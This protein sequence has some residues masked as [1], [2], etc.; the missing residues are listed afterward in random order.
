M[1]LYLRVQPLFFIPGK[2][3]L[4]LVRNYLQQMKWSLRKLFLTGSK[5]LPLDLAIFILRVGVAALMMR[6]GWP[7]LMRLLEGGEIK[8]GDPIG[9]GPALS[10]VLVVFAEVLCSISIALGLGTRVAAIPS[11]I[12]MIVIVFVVHSDAPFGRKELAV[13]YLLIYIVLLISGSRR[14]SLDKFLSGR[15]R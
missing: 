14:Y 9:L 10:L 1:R 5:D 11:I 13:F 15:H 8:F 3:N 12:N 6:H 7:K 4:Y 2:K